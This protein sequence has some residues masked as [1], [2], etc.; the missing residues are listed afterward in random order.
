MAAIVDVAN[1]YL[2]FTQSE[3]SKWILN[4]LK[5]QRYLYNVHKWQRTTGNS[6]IREAGT[7]DSVAWS[8]SLMTSSCQL[9]IVTH[10]IS[11]G[12][13]QCQVLTHLNMLAS[14]HKRGTSESLKCPEMAT[15][16]IQVTTF[17]FPRTTLCF[18]PLSVCPTVC[19]VCGLWW[20]S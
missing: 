20:A 3:V 13:I 16:L 14:E 4:Q 7:S 19:L 2:A 17:S 15:V 9:N 8:K 12:N 10:R 11:D 1:D 18:P 5:V 6:H